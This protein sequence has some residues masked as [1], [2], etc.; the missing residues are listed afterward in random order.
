MARAGTLPETDQER[1]AR[2]VNTYID[3][4][5]ALRSDLQKGLRSLDAGQGK[6]IDMANIIARAKHRHAGE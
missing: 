2:D 3:H 4:L 5:E 6:E 1:I